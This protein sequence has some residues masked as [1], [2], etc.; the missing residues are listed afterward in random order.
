MNESKKFF[1]DIGELANVAV[2]YGFNSNTASTLIWNS[3][4]PSKTEFTVLH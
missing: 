3:E 4:S 1:Q 2:E